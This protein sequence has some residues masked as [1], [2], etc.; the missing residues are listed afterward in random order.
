MTYISVKE[1]IEELEKSLENVD[2]TTPSDIVDRMKAELWKS[3]NRLET[4]TKME[5]TR[6]VLRND[7]NEKFDRQIGFIKSRMEAQKTILDNIGTGIKQTTVDA[8]VDTALGVDCAIPM[9]ILYRAF[10]AFTPLQKS[11]LRDVICSLGKYEFAGDVTSE[12]PSGKKIFVQKAGEGCKLRLT[13]QK[14]D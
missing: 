2:E 11:K 7:L 12:L 6:K 8:F 1:R 4:V 10:L 5:K 3:R 9:D 14:C 13:R